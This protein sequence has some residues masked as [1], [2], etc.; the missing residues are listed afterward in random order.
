M[1]SFSDTINRTPPWTKVAGDAFS[2]SLA[3]PNAPV[4]APPAPV[5]SDRAARTVDDLW[6]ELGDFA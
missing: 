3:A 4:H 1:D 5:A 2:R 6:D